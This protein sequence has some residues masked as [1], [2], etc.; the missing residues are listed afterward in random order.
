MENKM[1]EKTEL[2]KKILE[3]RRSVP[4]LQKRQQGH[5]YLYVGSSDVLGALREKMDEVG[6]LLIADIK[7]QRVTTTSVENNDRYGN[8]RITTTFFTELDVKYT[9]IDVETGQ[10]HE[11]MWYGQGLDVGGEK[12][13]GK[14]LTYAEK[15]FFLKQFNIPTDQDDP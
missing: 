6:L 12:G 15:Y 1:S 9:W 14:A 4:Y 5:Q 7:E 2:F 8:K 13:V 10:Y 11:I 3:V